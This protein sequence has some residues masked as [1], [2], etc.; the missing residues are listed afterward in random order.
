MRPRPKMQ[1]RL[2]YSFERE[3]GVDRP[4]GLPLPIVLHRK[5]LGHRTAD[6]VG[7]VLHHVP[8]R[9]AGRVVDLRLGV[10]IEE[11]LDDLF[12]LLL[13]FPDVCKLDP[14]LLKDN[15]PIAVTLNKR[16]RPSCAPAA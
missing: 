11:K 15:A 2:P 6:E 12:V 1:V 9:N 13:D 16:S 10:P 4:N 14:S 8:E 7:V 3:H 5:M